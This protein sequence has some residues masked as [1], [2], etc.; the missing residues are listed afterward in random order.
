M[1]WVEQEGAPKL[2]GG[3]I[4]EC[5]STR[6]SAKDPDSNLNTYVERKAVAHVRWTSA[7]RG[8]R[9]R[10]TGTH[11]RNVQGAE[12]EMPWRTARQR[13]LGLSCPV[14]KLYTAQVGTATIGCVQQWRDATAKD[15]HRVQWVA[16]RLYKGKGWREVR[17]CYVSLDRVP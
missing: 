15:I 9:I 13:L 4:R 12:A 3:H 2:S 7:R 6:R 1:A 14:A 11:N 16:Q 17:H 5:L 10:R 8:K